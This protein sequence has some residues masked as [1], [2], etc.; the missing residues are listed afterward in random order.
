MINIRGDHL[1]CRELHV[2]PL[3]SDRLALKNVLR[4][5]QRPGTLIIQL[6]PTLSTE[7]VSPASDTNSNSDLSN[8]AYRSGLRELP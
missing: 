2:L 4:G 6:T 3:L 8:A 7:L 5:W 1:K